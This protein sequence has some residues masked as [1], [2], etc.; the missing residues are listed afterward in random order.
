MRFL[1]KRSDIAA[2]LQAADV[3]LL[4]S[5]YE[6]LP[7][8]AIEAQAAGLPL[9]LS[10]A[11]SKE[12]AITGNVRFLRLADPPSVWADAI[13]DCKHFERRPTGES[14]ARAGYDRAHPSAAESE[15]RRYL[16]QP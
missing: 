10:D 8:V 12:S 6:G 5:F 7:I 11:V 2:I 16:A 14:M 3:F 13:L 9:I 1:G 15:L 4:P